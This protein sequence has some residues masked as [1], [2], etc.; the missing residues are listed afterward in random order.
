MTVK[1]VAE[2]SFPT[3]FGKFRI[4]AFKDSDKRDHL[5]LVRSAN[6]CSL[7]GPIPVRIHSKCVTGDT[8]GSLRCDC[9]DQLTAALWYLGKQECGVLIYLDQEGRGIGLVNKIRA[10]ALQDKG[11]DTV[12]AN[13]AL[14]FAD[15]LRHYKP[16]ADILKKLGVKQIKLITNNPDK[17]MQMKKYGI[18]VNCRIG[19]I[20][21]PTKYN[22]KYLVTKKIKMKHMLE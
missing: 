8:L 21:K 13:K 15:D 3:R 17:I 2:A 5:V 9:R 4:I 10:Y 18:K 12:E 20:T 6:G 11:M 1:K 14:G 7:N 16:A 22:R 19:L